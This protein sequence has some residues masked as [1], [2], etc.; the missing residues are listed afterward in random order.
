MAASQILSGIDTG[1]YDIWLTWCNPSTGSRFG[2]RLYVPFQMIGIGKAPY[3]F[4]SQDDDGGSPSEPSWTSSGSDPSYPYTWPTSVGYDIAA[5]PTA[6][7][8]SLSIEVL[9]QDLS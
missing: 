3:W 9:I 5:T 8:T 1:P 7:H 2:T 4:I 6:G